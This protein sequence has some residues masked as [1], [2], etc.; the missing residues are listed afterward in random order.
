VRRPILD[1]EI[2]QVFHDVLGF[3]LVNSLDYCT[4]ARRRGSGDEDV[5]EI[6]FGRSNEM[7]SPIAIGTWA[8]G[9]PRTVGRRPVGWSGNDDDQA[10]Q[11]LI[12]AFESG[13]THWDTADVYGDGHAERLIGKAWS[14]VPRREIFLASK[15][16]WDP[17]KYRHAYERRNIRE[18]AERSL[19]LL[20]TDV[21]DLYYLHHCDFGPE[22][23][24]LEGAV[25]TLR[26][27]RAAG[28]IRYI[29]LSDWSSRRLLRIARRMV[30]D[31]VQTYRNVA[32][33]DYAESGLEAWVEEVDAG[34]AFFSP[35]KHGLLLGKY[36]Q[37][38]VFPAGDMRS[39]IS[40]FRDPTALARIRRA[41]DEI[42][43]RFSD[44]PNPVL[45]ALTGYL[46]TDSP[47][48]SVLLGQ[49]DPAQVDAAATVGEPLD[50]EDAAWVRGLY[51]AVD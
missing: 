9:G 8:H 34:V 50:A 37:P 13:I 32:D 6:R 19:R 16:G 25:E 48:A 11:A 28:K 41:R 29:G 22:E 15:V 26:D 10:S 38:Q 40:D 45:Y 39:S 43:R 49:R 33:D 51:S 17:G 4:L 5:K 42:E 27:L 14:A 3:T 35:L 30:P 23:R 36:E 46:L 1:L 47:T 44:V 12:R 24:Y 21:I 20:A 18:R 2:F 31:V 7:V